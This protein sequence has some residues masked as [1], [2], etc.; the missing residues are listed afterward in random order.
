MKTQDFFNKVQLSLQNKL[1]FVLY[2]KPTAPEN[3]EFL[4]KSFFQKNKQLYV[5]ENYTESG[6]VMA[7]FDLNAQKSPLIPTKK[8][9]QINISLHTSDL[10]FAENQ[11]PLDKNIQETDK[12]NH[13]DLVERG[14]QEIKKGKL[15]KV[16]LSRK[17]NKTIHPDIPAIF[18]RLLLTYP[19]AFVYCWYHPEIGLWMGA[20]P[21]TLL[22]IN[23]ENLTTMALA[24]TKPV[25]GK[26]PPQ[27]TSKEIQEQQFVTDFITDT[28]KEEVTQLKVGKVE[29][30]RAGKLWHLKCDISA[31][32]KSPE[33]LKQILKDLHPT[34]AV[35][36]MPKLASKDFIID[37]ESYNREFYTGFLGELNLEN[38][39]ELFVNLRCMQ[40]HSNYCEIYV[41]G[42]IVMDSIP[43]SEWEETVNKSQ[44]MLD[45]VE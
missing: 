32:M 42:G 43:E 17:I 8:S 12:Q 40:L 14:I 13:L 23:K 19:T 34:P 9:E 25:E 29:N 30:I 4:I 10:S 45:I 11:N 33:N 5:A 24:S 31:K 16:V 21:E 36:G 15:K 22:K 20:T 28:L 18:K 35:C 41:G 38:K 37:E 6:F 3:S 26:K 44:T 7:P 39:S 27:W 2:R 1:P